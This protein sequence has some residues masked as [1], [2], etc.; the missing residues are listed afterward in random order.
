MRVG[1]RRSGGEARR[2]RNS[3]D[4][5]LL[6][7]AIE[8]DMLIVADSIVELDRIAELANSR[9]RGLGG[10]SVTGFPLDK[11]SR[12]RISPQVSG[13][14]RQPHLRHPRFSPS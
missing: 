8:N 10:A 7:L 4:N 9:G 13:Q 11:V 2:E 3:K 14:V 5:G 6:N 12:P 1:G